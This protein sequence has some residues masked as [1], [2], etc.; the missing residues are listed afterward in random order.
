M[1]LFRR[2]VQRIHSKEPTVR[3]QWTP[4]NMA[5]LDENG[6]YSVCRI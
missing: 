2:I 4:I 1:Y 3:I 5:T 6:Y